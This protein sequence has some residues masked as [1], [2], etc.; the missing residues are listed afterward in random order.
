MPVIQGADL[1]SVT[2]ERK[3]FDEGEYLVTI[4]SSEFGGDQNKMLIIK[5]KIEAAPND[6]DVGREF[7]DW[8]NVIQNDGK[9]NQISMAHVKRYMEAVFGKGAPETEGNP[10][11]TDPLNGHQVRLY[12]ILDTYKDKKSGEDKTNNKVKQI[13]SA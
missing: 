6:A 8:V 11:D 7:W 3:A 13:L 12:L 4:Q 9:I 10:P 2:T 1:S 5:T